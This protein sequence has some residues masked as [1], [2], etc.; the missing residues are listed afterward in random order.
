MEG[1]GFLRR[2]ARLKSTGGADPAPLDASAT[3]PATASSAADPLAAASAPA[4]PASV[5]DARQEDGP[6]RPAPTL[7]DVARL[8][9]DSDYSA[10][11]ARGVDKNVQR[12]ALKKLF[13]DPHFHV[14]D[15]LD[16]YMDDFN[17]P[18]PMS[19]VMLA[20]LQ[21][22]QDVLG[23]LLGDKEEQPEDGDTAQAAQETLPP[24]PQQGNA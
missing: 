19:P 7:D 17:K 12:L 15:G 5:P 22:A 14:M 24:P 11:V 16:I 10:F 13:A 4:A 3:A 9:A 8:T 23:R 6:A 2:W 20:S 1:E 18:S 21:H